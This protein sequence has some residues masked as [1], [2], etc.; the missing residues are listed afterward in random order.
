MPGMLAAPIDR[1]PNC[2]R[3][4]SPTSLLV[5]FIFLLA[6]PLPPVWVPD[7][8]I[9]A[10]SRSRAANISGVTSSATAT[11]ILKVRSI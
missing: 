9:R 8:P 5:F 1:S 4:S 6:V 7:T 2:K 3:L 11:V 10:R